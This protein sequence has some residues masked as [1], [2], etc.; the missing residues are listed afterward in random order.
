M[1]APSAKMKVRLATSWGM[2]L[3]VVISL[4]AAL[5]VLLRAYVDPGGYVSP[6]SFAYLRQA[7]FIIEG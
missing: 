1:G 4:I 5:G 3:A 6:D 2:W 7:A